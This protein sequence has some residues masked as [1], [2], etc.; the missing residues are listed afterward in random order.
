[1]LLKCNKMSKTA[2]YPCSRLVLYYFSVKVIHTSLGIIGTQ[3][4]SGLNDKKGS[5]FLVIYFFVEEEAV[6]DF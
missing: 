5:S 1:M 3:E 6:Q 2:P 4:Y